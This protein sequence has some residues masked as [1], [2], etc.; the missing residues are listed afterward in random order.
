MSEIQAFFQSL[1]D[2]DI[3]AFYTPVGVKS[4]LQNYPEFKQDK[5]LFVTYGPSTAKVLKDHG[6][7]VEVEAPTPQAP[8]VSKALMLYL[9]NMK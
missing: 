8:S 2:F 4:L 6:Y 3:L 9:E 1:K 7:S 5:L